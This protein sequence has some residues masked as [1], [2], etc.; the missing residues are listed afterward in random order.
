MSNVAAGYTFAD[1]ETV[2][3]ENLHGLVEGADLTSVGPSDLYTGLDYARTTTAGSPSAGD[4][5]INGADG[6]ILFYKGSAYASQLAHP[7]TITMTNADGSTLTRGMAVVVAGTNSVKRSASSVTDYTF[8]G[9]VH[10]ATI[11]NTAAGQIAVRGVIA[12]LPVY[13]AV[14]VAPAGS[15][16]QGPTTGRDYCL[17]DRD[18]PD[19]VYGTAYIGQVLQSVSNESAT[20]TVAAY[21]WR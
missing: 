19:S 20:V 9:I 18:T 14:S 15:Y 13:S 7:Y 3:A 8:F 12:D 4:N 10:D 2:L 21:I 11:A 1:R 5:V 6:E 16:L 17:V